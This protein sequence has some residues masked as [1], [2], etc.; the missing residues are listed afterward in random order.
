MF[1]KQYLNHHICEKY[2][3]KYSFFSKNL[4]SKYFSIPQIHSH[5][6][7]T[8]IFEKIENF[9]ILNDVYMTWKNV[10]FYHIW[11]ILQEIH[12]IWKEKKYIHWDFCLQNILLSKDE[13]FVIDFESPKDYENIDY[14]YKN[15]YYVDIGIFIMKLFTTFPIY[16]VNSIYKK[17]YKTNILNFLEWYWNKGNKNQIITYTSKEFSRKE[18]WLWSLLKQWKI[19]YLPYIVLSILYYKFC[20]LSLKKWLKKY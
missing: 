3:E 1:Q 19:Y 13:Y 18:T 12:K 5:N 7:N 6:K 8:I 9:Q 10:D 4:H 2:Y 17:N 20:I 16:K 15:T 11:K 14:Y